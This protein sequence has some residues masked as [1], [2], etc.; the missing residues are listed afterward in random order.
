MHEEVSQY[1]EKV[2]QKMKA[3]IQKCKCRMGIKASNNESYRSIPLS[4]TMFLNS[5][6]C[7]C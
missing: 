7:G 3:E 6:R 4:L 5:E 1:A 2:A